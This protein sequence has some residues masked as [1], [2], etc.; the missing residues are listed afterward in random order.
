[1]WTL[2]GVG[3]L[4][5]LLADVLVTVMHPHGGG[6]VLSRTLQRRIWAG[7][8]AVGA[9]LPQRS[10]DR[11]LV[12]GGPVIATLTPAFWFALLVVGFTLIYLPHI[13]GFLFL[14]GEP[15]GGW[16][17]AIYYSGYTATTLGVGDVVADLPALRLLS[18][19][20]AFGGFALISVSITYI[21][22]VYRE[23]GRASAL[24]AEIALRFAGGRSP[25]EAAPAGESAWLDEAARTL[26]S[27]RRAHQQYP[28]LH[29]FRPRE[30][31]SALVVQLEHLLALRRSWQQ[32]AAPPGAAESWRAAAL[33]TEEYVQWVSAH[34]PPQRFGGGPVGGDA[35]DLDQSHRRLMAYLGYHGG[36]ADEAP[37]PRD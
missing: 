7:V 15:R 27:V 34:V 16:I 30:R 18:I 20:Q 9:R 36:E 21:L 22:G 32:G 2:A 31:A 19:V 12:L 26:L 33:A 10:A 23:A 3:V 13:A 4:A 28:I 14:P 25:A 35:A 37:G 11:W 24:A 8:R 5:L 6:G 1:M 17:E 29:L